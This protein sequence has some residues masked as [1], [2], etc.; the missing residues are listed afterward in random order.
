MDRTAPAGPRLLGRL[1][2]ELINRSPQ[3]MSCI[4]NYEIDLRGEAIVLDALAAAAAKEG[5]QGKG[6]ANGAACWRRTR[7]A[8]AALPPPPLAL[9]HA[10]L[11]R[12]SNPARLSLPTNPCAGNKIGAIENLGAT[13][14]RADTPLCR[15]LAEP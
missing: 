13:E 11:R 8:A 1:T 3:Y 10:C 7:C 15:S 9:Q 6:A 12:C 14:V 5:T 2:A 4:N